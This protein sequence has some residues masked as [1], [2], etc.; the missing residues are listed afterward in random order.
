MAC[1]A[2]AL[3]RTNDDGDLTDAAPSV[4]IG[5]A[6]ESRVVRFRYDVAAEVRREIES[7]LHFQLLRELTPRPQAFAPNPV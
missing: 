7:L 6:R 5:I 4:Y 3:F 1:H 2:D